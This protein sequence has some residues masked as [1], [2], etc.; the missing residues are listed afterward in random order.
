MA[1]QAA[2]LAAVRH[3]GGY[4]GAVSCGEGAVGE[5]AGRE[6]RHWYAGGAAAARQGGRVRQGQEG[7]AGG[8]DGAGAGPGDLGTESRQT[9]RL[10]ARATRG[11][12]AR[13]DGR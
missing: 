3:E 7:V 11:G 2:G 6:Q 9:L 13:V 8:C 5:G 1:A 12:L 4:V 10:G